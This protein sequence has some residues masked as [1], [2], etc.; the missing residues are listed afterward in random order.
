MRM[1]WKT[2]PKHNPLETKYSIASTAEGPAGLILASAATRAYAQ[3]KEK[4]DLTFKLIFDIE[5]TANE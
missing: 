2:S 1:G 4:I 5:A 3:S